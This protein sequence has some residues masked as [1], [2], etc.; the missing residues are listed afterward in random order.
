MR[1]RELARAAIAV[2]CVFAGLAGG[3]R[4]AEPVDLS[5]KWHGGW[6]SCQTG[7]H[8][9]L[10][11][12]FLKI[13][14]TCYQVRFTGTFW[15]AIPFF[16]TVNLAAA[17]QGDGTVVLSGSPQLP[18]FGTFHFAAVATDRECKA[19]YATSRDDGLFTLHR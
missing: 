5:G 7:H 4:G 8:G 12:R 9:I 11:A 18:L 3:A 16:F 14:D 2:V 1:R 19:T 13:N 6:V 17:E 10:R 15:V